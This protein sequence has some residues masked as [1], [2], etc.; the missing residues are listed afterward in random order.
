MKEHFHYSRRAS[1]L[2]LFLFWTGG[3]GLAQIA[4]SSGDFPTATGITLEFYG[5]SVGTVPVDVGPAGGPQHWDFSQGPTDRFIVEHI[6]EKGDT[7]FGDQFPEANLVFDTNGLN[8]A[9]IDTASGYQY[10][11]L[12]DDNLMLLGA[13]SE[14][15]LGIPLALALDPSLTMLPL[16]LEFGATWFDE[17]EYLAILEDVVENPSPNPFF[18]DPYLDVKVEI[19]MSTAGEVEGW[20]TVAVP[21]GEFEALR[22]RRNDRTVVDLS[23]FL[24]FVFVPV[25]DSTLTVVTYDWYTKGLGSVLTVTSRPDESNPD[26][27]EASRVRRLYRTN[28]VLNRPPEITSAS[29]VRAF[30]D[31]PFAYVA[32]AT[33]PD[34]DSLSFRF[35]DYPGWLSPSDSVIS[36]MPLEGTTDSTFMVIADDGALSDSLIVDVTVVD[37]NDPPSILPMPDTSFTSGETIFLFLDQYVEDVDSPDS[38]LVWTASALSESLLVSIEDRRAVLTAP[39]YEGSTMVL[40]TVTDDSLASD[41]DTIGVTVFGR[42]NRAPQLVSDST[43]KAREDELFSYVARATDPDDDSLG[44]LFSDYPNWLMPSDSVLSG[45]PREGTVDTSFVVSVTDGLL[46]DSL[47]VKVSVLAINDPP[48]LAPFPDT[49]FASGETL[50]IHLGRYVDDVDSPDS[51]LSWSAATSNDSLLVNIEGE[52]AWLMAPDFQ[53]SA[54][55]LFSVVDESLAS[56]SDTMRVTVLEQTGVS[57]TEEAGP[58]HRFFLYQNRPNPFNPFT[59]IGYEIPLEQ[60]GAPAPVTLR[61]FNTLGQEVRRL[62]DEPKETGIYTVLWDG[63]DQGGDELPSGIYFSVFTSEGSTAIQKMILIR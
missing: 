12:G 11:N 17:T 16:P 57:F 53:G 8:I 19:E 44:F 54:W 49:S 24:G 56:A 22:V 1:L 29:T 4:I 6:V 41:V 20:G 25:F 60:S 10:M 3:T 43:G 31:R 13:G 48:V 59:V 35:T 62:V 30:E 55:V 34:G 2:F 51:L 46:T 26:F 18:P 33:D 21:W 52:F 37:V 38:T 27:T 63:R 47:V 58:P 50:L 9:G 40:F 61:V 42:P 32:Q 23:V 5:N 15:V 39:N 36:G 45:I 14:N 28:A 7:P